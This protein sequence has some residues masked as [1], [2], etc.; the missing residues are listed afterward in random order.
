[1]ENGYKIDSSRIT[2]E[3]VEEEVLIIDLET[4]RYYTTSGS[5]SMIW[6]MLTKGYSVQLILNKLFPDGKQK[7]PA[8]VE[9]VK[10]FVEELQVEGLISPDGSGSTEDILGFK[11]F[12]NLNIPLLEKY[13]DMQELLLIDPI[14]DVDSTGWP[15][16]NDESL[17]SSKE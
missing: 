3:V 17:D 4:G 12:G 2:F 8:M 15:K 16:I 9:G 6:Q 1:M 10:S 13:T 5:G 14:H 11:V 7:D